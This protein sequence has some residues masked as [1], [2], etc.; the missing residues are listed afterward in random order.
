[1]NM[2]KQLGYKPNPA[3]K[4]LAARRHRPIVGVILNSEGNAF[5]DEIIRGIAAYQPVGSRARV[6]RTARYT[7][8]DD[9]YNANPD[10]TAAALRSS[11]S[12]LPSAFCC[13]SRISN[14]HRRCTCF[15]TSLRPLSSG[16]RL[17]GM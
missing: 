13:S 1:M 3:G 11:S 5:F 14:P 10:S 16:A 8:I 4:A 9:C 12:I 2:V 15:S 7:V 17:C 6:V